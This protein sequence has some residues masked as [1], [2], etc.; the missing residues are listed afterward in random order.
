MLVHAF[1]LQAHV[2]ITFHSISVTLDL[3]VP[4]Q[5]GS[6]SLVKAGL[7]HSC[8]YTGRS[9]SGSRSQA[10]PSRTWGWGGCGFSLH[11]QKGCDIWAPQDGAA[12]RE[13]VTHQK[14][15][16]EEGVAQKRGDI[17]S[18]PS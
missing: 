9:C 17:I 1:C 8:S 11:F 10:L 3:S 18:H 7:W 16:R 12:W 6:A 14:V 5:I 13:Q 15:H 2:M 4:L